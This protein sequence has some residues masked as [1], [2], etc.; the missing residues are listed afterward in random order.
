MIKKIHRH[1]I[2][3][4]TYMLHNTCNNESK[5]CVLPIHPCESSNFVLNKWNWLNFFRFV[6]LSLSLSLSLWTDASLFSIFTKYKQPIIVSIVYVLKH[7]PV[8]SR[9]RINFHMKTEI[10]WCISQQKRERN[11]TGRN[12]N[13]NH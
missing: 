9:F 11:H 6:S 7:F 2:K 10:N 12:K 3:I 8:V 5:K 1:R 13:K 4:Y